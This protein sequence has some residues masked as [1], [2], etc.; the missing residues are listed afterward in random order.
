MIPLNYLVCNSSG[1][2]S[3]EELKVIRNELAKIEEYFLEK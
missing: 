2:A 1:M 3:Y